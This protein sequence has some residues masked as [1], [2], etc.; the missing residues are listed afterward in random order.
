MNSVVGEIGLRAWKRGPADFTSDEQSSNQGLVN[1][2]IIVRDAS[3]NPR[4]APWRGPLARV[5]TELAPH[6][7]VFLRQY[8]QHRQHI[9]CLVSDP[10]NDGLA[11]RAVAAR[12][13]DDADGAD[14]IFGACANPDHS[15]PHPA[16][17][18]ERDLDAQGAEEGLC[19][20]QLT[21]ERPRA[22]CPWGATRELVSSDLGTQ[23]Q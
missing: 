10:S 1:R 4:F 17:T 23:T 19:P 21:G 22:F 18:P 13:A 3:S 2:D 14:G 20:T 12:S 7:G 11:L 6:K 9:S 16:F 15:G 8:R 5:I